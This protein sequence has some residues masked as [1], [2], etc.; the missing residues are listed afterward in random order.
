MFET[1]TERECCQ[2]S[3]YSDVSDN[4]EDKQITSSSKAAFIAYW[5]SLIVLIKK[6]FT[7]YLYDAAYNKKPR[8]QRISI[9]RVT[10]MPRRP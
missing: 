2:E 7:F 3:H 8:F 5:T 6:M 9:D 4:E 1:E 10:K